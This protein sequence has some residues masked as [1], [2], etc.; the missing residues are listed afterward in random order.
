VTA[1]WA[2]TNRIAWL[3]AYQPG[4]N[5]ALQAPAGS[6]PRQP[7]AAIYRRAQ[8]R[9]TVELFESV[10]RTEG[11]RFRNEIED[12]VGGKQIM[13]E[14]PSGNPVE[15]FEPSRP[16]A[17]LGDALRCKREMTNRERG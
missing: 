13:A 11:I 6:P 1:G 8:P 16:E 10:T 14:D 12:G 7:V 17:R 3:P 15:L 4:S 5:G 2:E 9:S